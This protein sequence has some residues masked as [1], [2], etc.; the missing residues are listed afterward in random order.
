MG[1]RQRDEKSQTGPGAQALE[2]GGAPSQPDLPLRDQSLGQRNR[3]RAGGRGR[4]PPA[5]AEVAKSNWGYRGR[6]RACLGLLPTQG[7]M[8][9]SSSPPGIWHSLVFSP[10]CPPW[11]PLGLLGHGGHTQALMAFQRSLSVLLMLPVWQGMEA[12]S[13]R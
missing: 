6:D 4:Q 11:T 8:T 1:K 7:P 12:M 10:T 3:E 13:S 5:R 9:S 2:K